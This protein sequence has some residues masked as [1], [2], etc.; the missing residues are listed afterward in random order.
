MKKR[1]GM[2][3]DR[4][5]EEETISLNVVLCVFNFSIAEVGVGR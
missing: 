5:W 4:G 1:K 2:N 3:R